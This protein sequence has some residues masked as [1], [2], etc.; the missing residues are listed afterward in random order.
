MLLSVNQL[1]RSAGQ[2]RMIP[3]YI[4]GGLRHP[5]FSRTNWT[6]SGWLCVGGSMAALYAKEAKVNYPRL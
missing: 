2:S 5:P 1:R 4:N 6:K 3:W